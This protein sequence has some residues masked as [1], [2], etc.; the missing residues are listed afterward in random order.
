MGV[1]KTKSFRVHTGLLHVHIT[2][3]SPTTTTTRPV[4]VQRRG[5]EDGE[6]PGFRDAEGRTEK[7]RGEKRERSTSS[8]HRE[9]VY[10]RSL[11]YGPSEGHTG[12]WSWGD[13]SRPQ[14]HTTVVVDRHTY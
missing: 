3:G 14:P 7:V 6:S 9:E 11:G 1:P 13:G 10:T 4:V 5:R 12:S 2:Q 8:R